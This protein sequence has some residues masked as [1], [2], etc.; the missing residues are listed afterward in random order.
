MFLN[1]NTLYHI[2]KAY[3]FLNLQIQLEFSSK[4]VKL[5]DNGIRV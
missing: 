5:L 1:K 2:Q 3:Q 4:N